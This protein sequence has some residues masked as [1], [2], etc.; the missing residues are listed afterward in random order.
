MRV[1]L[2]GDPHFKKDNL[3]IMSR[4]CQEIL[5]II[6]QRKPDIV[7]SL[8]DTLDTHERLYLP[9]LTDAT[10]FYIEIS[11]RCELVVLIGNH[12]RINNSDF[13][14]S[15]HPFVGL[16]FYPNITIVDTTI[17]DK[18]KNFIY[19]PYVSCGRFN[20]ALAKVDYSPFQNGVVN[21]N[22]EHPLLI[23]THSEFQ[24]CIMGMKPS[25]TGDIWSPNLPQIFSGHIHEYQVIPGVVYVGTFLQ[26]N[27]G[28]GTDKALMMLYLEENKGTIVM[29]DP[30]EDKVTRPKILVER[31][32]LL[33]APTRVTIHLT[34]AEL[35]DFAAKIPLGCLVKV[36]VHVDATELTSLK[37]NPY[38]LAMKNMV[39]KVIEKVESNR[40]SVAQQM[41]NNFK[42]KGA[43]TVDKKIYGIEEIVTAMLK[44][45]LYTLHIYNTKIAM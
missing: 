27:Y 13:L 43:L 14:S 37:H 35:P 24:G 1:I 36:V 15:I 23:F 34:A 8:G 2:L 25:T 20:E 42:E 6:D 41:V 32:K 45:D 22:A 29:E 18:Q 38:Y 7:I 31:I 10:K 4:V 19:V 17:W 33:S 39:D 26:Q 5:E 21:L 11:K 44:D 30:I 16:K 12:D 9:A 3:D 28:E 40:A